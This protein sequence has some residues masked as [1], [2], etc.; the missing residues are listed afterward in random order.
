MNPANRKLGCLS[1]DLAKIKTVKINTA[2]LVQFYKSAKNGTR[3]N[4]YIYSM[5]HTTFQ[6]RFSRCFPGVFPE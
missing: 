4:K 6:D 1:P 3:E 5:V 2:K